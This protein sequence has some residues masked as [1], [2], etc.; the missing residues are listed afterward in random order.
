MINSPNRYFKNIK[1]NFR[2]K[3]K[4]K[5]KSTKRDRWPLNRMIQKR[6]ANEE[7]RYT[8]I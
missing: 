5:K 3:R 1:S 6:E 8:K 4:R 7:S 2:F